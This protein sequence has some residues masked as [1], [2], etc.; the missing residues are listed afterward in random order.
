MRRSQRKL[1]TNSGY[2]TARSEPPMKKN[3]ADMVLSS[4]RSISQDEN[5]L[6]KLLRACFYRMIRHVWIKIIPSSPSDTEHFSYIIGQK[7]STIKCLLL[8]LNYLRNYGNTVRLNRLKV[9][10]LEKMSFD[11]FHLSIGS[12]KMNKCKDVY[13]IC[14]NKPIYLLPC[15]QIS[16][17]HVYSSL[18]CK[19]RSD[20]K[21]ENLILTNLD[22]SI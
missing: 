22:I 21:L 9:A 20:K 11:N 1:R 10:E 12:T 6:E 14:C 4:R 7:W 5:I 17:C 8:R 18:R 15:Q 13:Y 3:T 19:S 2:A 16:Q